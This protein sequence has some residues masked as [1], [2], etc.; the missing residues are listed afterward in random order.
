[1]IAGIVA[2]RRNA[3][4]EQHSYDQQIIPRVFSFDGSSSSSDT[5]CTI[6]AQETWE[7]EDYVVIGI[8]HQA[9]NITPPP[10]MSLITQLQSTVDASLYLS[11]FAG[12][13]GSASAWEFSMAPGCIFSATGRAFGNVDLYNPIAAIS[14]A[15]D[16]QSL[17]SSKDLIVPSINIDG[18]RK[19][20]LEITAEN[21]YIGEEQWNTSN[22]LRYGRAF[23]SYSGV[24]RNTINGAYPFS[25]STSK[26]VPPFIKPDIPIPAAIGAAVIMNASAGSYSFTPDFSALTDYLRGLS[27]GGY[28]LIIMK[29]GIQ[30]LSESG[31]LAR[32]PSETVNPALAFD[33]NTK[34]PIAS[35]SKIITEMAVRIAQR[36]GFLSID[37]TV[38]ELAP[39]L[40][41]SPTV[42]GITIRNL[43][44]MT[45]GVSAAYN[46]LGAYPS[47]V[48]SWSLNS[49]INIGEWYLYQNGNFALIQRVL[50]EILIGGY[51]DFVQQNIFLPLSISATQLTPSDGV[52][53]YQASGTMAGVGFTVPAT[54]VGGWNMS[55]MELA[56][57][58]REFRNPSNLPR[59]IVQDMLNDRYRMASS[60]TWSG[61]AHQHDGLL[62]DVNG[63]GCRSLLF[64]APLGYDIS[65]ITNTYD[66]ST[67]LISLTR[68][69]FQ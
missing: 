65:V 4:G 35:V 43:L 12:A 19:F 44:R 37:Q 50:D 64:R 18:S 53:S 45:S 7:A 1:M 21:S 38:G 66:A 28:A 22:P 10:G 61:E 15:S 51:A 34:F 14:S 56:K 36:A 67:T 33:L 20:V 59:Q 39:S 27:C 30:I 17:G 68:A 29:D 41:L 48:D 23:S 25:I 52:L 69:A 24:T 60:Y 55:C 57:I 9:T 26:F 6:Q 49:A 3:A 2:W 31:G 42:S 32:M 8:S 47:E 62:L 40:S 11:I 63:R 13:K 5:L 46:V 54:A 16:I 58:S